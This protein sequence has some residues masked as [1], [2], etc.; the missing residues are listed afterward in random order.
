MNS[1]FCSTQQVNLMSSKPPEESHLPGTQDQTLDNKKA[2]KN[3]YYNLWVKMIWGDKMVQSA[4]PVTLL[5]GLSAQIPPGELGNKTDFRHL[6]I[7]ITAVFW[8]QNVFSSFLFMNATSL[9]FINNLSRIWPFPCCNVVTK[10]KWAQIQTL[11]LTTS[12]VLKNAG[13]AYCITSLKDTHMAGD[14]TTRARCRQHLASR[15]RVI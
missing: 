12:S 5:V 11:W 14:V 4:V 3:P 9:N 15:D 6:P 8:Q 10:C 2:E 1:S 7:L 13:E